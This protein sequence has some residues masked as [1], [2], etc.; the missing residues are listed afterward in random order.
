MPKVKATIDREGNVTL[1]V[2]EG[3]GS[4]CLELT[5]RMEQALGGN[6]KRTLKGEYYEGVPAHD[7]EYS[8]GG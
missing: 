1:E 3:I 6:Q 8:H 2:L 7:E 4:S 5:R